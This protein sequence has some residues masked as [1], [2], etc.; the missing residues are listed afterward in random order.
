M[1]E[2]ESSPTNAMIDDTVTRGMLGIYGGWKSGLEKLHDLFYE[3]AGVA[4]MAES[5]FLL[6]SPAETAK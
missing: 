3:V 5:A 2:G 6:M 1:E 4:T